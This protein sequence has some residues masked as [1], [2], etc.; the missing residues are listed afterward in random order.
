MQNKFKVTIIDAVL[1]CPQ[2]LLYIIFLLSTPLQIIVCQIQCI[3]L[4]RK[5]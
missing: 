5:P 2:T 1:K 4:E 3:V